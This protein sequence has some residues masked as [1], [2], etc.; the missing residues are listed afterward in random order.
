MR[1][2]IPLLLCL[3]LACFACA[4][5]NEP[6]QIPPLP[7]ADLDV[8]L[9]AADCS[10]LQSFPGKVIRLVFSSGMESRTSVTLLSND[11]TVRTALDAGVWRIFA[12]IDDLDTD[13][14]DYAGLLMLAVSNSTSAD[15]L[16]QQTGSATGLV[17]DESNRSVAGRP[18]QHACLDCDA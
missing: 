10:T 6:E 17:L 13:G 8:S 1:N 5:Q 12:E 2:A 7:A 4:Q 3:F 11:S 16:L 18:G 15:L 9:H 14:S